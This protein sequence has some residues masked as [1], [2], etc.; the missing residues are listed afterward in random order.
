MV[1]QVLAFAKITCDLKHFGHAAR[2]IGFPPS[3]LVMC[4]ETTLALPEGAIFT[5]L[6]PALKRAVLKR[7]GPTPRESLYIVTL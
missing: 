1:V 7:K 5:V 3:G 2:G 4:F 6:T